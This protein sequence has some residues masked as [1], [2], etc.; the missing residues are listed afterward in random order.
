M[1][2]MAYNFVIQ[3]YTLE[4]SFFNAISPY[5]WSLKWKDAACEFNK[6]F[7]SGST[8]PYQTR[9]TSDKEFENWLNKNDT[10]TRSAKIQFFN[11]G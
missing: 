4:G 3:G 11:L 10:W 2:G 8:D 7:K 5:Y 9:F 1:V 6:I